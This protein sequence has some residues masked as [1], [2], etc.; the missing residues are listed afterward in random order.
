MNGFCLTARSQETTELKT[1]WYFWDASPSP[2]LSLVPSWIYSNASFDSARLRRRR[3]TLRLDSARVT[4]FL[5]D[6]L[7]S[8][9]VQPNC[10]SWTASWEL[11]LSQLWPKAELPT[12]RFVYSI[13]KLSNGLCQ[14]RAVS[15]KKEQRAA[16]YFTM[17]DIVHS[18]INLAS[19]TRYGI[20]NG[21]K[22]FQK[23]PK[24]NLF[25][26]LRF[27]ILICAVSYQSSTTRYGIA[28]GAKYFQ[29]RPY[30]YL[31][32]GNLRFEI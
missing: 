13:S 6:C 27:E 22:Y 23:R 3:D 19:T 17:S 1:L 4:A 26:N 30:L 11:Q 31:C 7:G 32:I 21:A 2:L 25:G 28:N 10:P 8:S 16:L 5:P 9:V 14:T 18:L 29:K 24:N 20:I 15:F 12:L